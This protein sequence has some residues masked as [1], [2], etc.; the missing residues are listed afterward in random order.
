MPKTYEPIATTTVGTATN[1]ITF[2]SIPGTYTDLIAVIDGTVGNNISVRFN[3]DSGANYS[4]TRIQG[5]GSSASSARTTNSTSII[6]S[7]S[8]GKQVSIWQFFNYSNSVT[9]KTAL[10][11]G[12]G[13]TDQ[14]EAYVGLWRNTAAVTSIE[15]L[16]STGNYAT[17][18]TL[19]LYG[20]KA[21]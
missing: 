16:T 15:F 21:A 2:S 7:Y 6:G 8:A 19:T 20:I 12:N 5:N 3:S 4:M 10:D 17:G 18:T 11:R 9:N 1:T 13:A 14:V